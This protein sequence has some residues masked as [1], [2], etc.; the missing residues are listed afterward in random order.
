MQSLYI[1]FFVITKISKYFAIN[2]MRHQANDLIFLLRKFLFC[3]IE[4]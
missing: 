4:A 2:V 3:L 1:E